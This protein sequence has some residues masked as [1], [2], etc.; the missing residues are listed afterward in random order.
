VKTATDWLTLYVEE[1]RQ[2]ASDPLFG[3]SAEARA[4]AAIAEELDA[5]RRAYLYA[6]PTTAEAAQE[7]G[8]SAEQLRKLRKQGLWSGQRYDLPRR[9]GRTVPEARGLSLAQEV[10]STRRRTGT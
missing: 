3:G 10:L 5:R 7:S 9:P 4:A 6:T 2:R 1:L 8:Y